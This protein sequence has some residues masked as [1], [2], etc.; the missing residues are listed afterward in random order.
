M[1]PSAFS[2]KVSNTS[3]ESARLVRTDCSLRQVEPESKDG[4]YDTGRELVKALECVAAIETAIEDV[5]DPERSMG[6]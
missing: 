4:A 3:T 5:G 2:S 6:R 1:V